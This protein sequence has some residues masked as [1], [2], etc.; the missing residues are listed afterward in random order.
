MIVRRGRRLGRTSFPGGHCARYT[1]AMRRRNPQ[2]RVAWIWVGIGV[3]GVAGVFLPFVFGMEGMGGGFAIAVV[4]GF[5]ALS[6]AIA[7]SVFAARARILG[8]LFRGADV[9]ACWTYPEADRTNHAKKELA[10]E[11]K[12]SW[13][14][15][16]I[17]AAFALLIG[18][19]FLIADPDA[20]RFVLLVM[21]GLVALLAVVAF[22]APS[23]RHRK[24][25][26]AVPEAIVSREGA[27]VFG[28]LHTWRLLGARIEDV[29]L[30]TGAKPVLHVTYSAPVLY[31]K[32]FLTRQSYTVSIPVPPG[33]Q[34]RAEEV[35]QALRGGG[36]KAAS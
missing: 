17:I 18:I 36:G 20:G 29:D 7:A 12:A 5:L 32:V 15:L 19:G 16:L 14:L 6:A 27:Y 11:K 25:R 26:R 2:A 1:A 21:V 31:G 22:L 3:L 23:I 30:A 4:C 13:V 24:R 34:G 28:M 35:A 33:E 10:E 8:R 9:L